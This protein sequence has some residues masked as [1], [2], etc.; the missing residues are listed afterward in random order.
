MIIVR[1]DPIS[2]ILLPE[3][4]FSLSD[5]KF[6]ATCLAVLDGDLPGNVTLRKGEADMPMKMGYRILIIRKHLVVYVVK[7]EYIQIRRVLHG[8]H[9]YGYLL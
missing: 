2:L 6:E 9:Q 1:G 5:P 8:A 3:R 7:K 4:P